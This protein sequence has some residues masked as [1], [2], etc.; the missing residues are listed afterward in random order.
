VVVVLV[1]ATVLSW[2]WRHRPAGTAA[3]PVT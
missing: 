1:T 3:V 2:V